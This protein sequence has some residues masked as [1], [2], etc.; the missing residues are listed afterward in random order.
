M[1]FL[2]IARERAAVYA[3]D[4]RVK[5]ILLSG[6]ASVGQTDAASDVDLLV[7]Y[8]G[9][10]G[11]QLLQA[12]KE[13][14]VASGG[15]FFWGTGE[16]FAV[17]HFQQ[18]SGIRVDV[19][20]AQVSQL[21]DR[22]AQLLEKHSL[23]L[24]LHLVATGILQAVPLYGA[25]VAE[26]WKRR[27]SAFPE[28]LATALVREHLRFS[29]RAVFMEMGADRGDLPFL[30]ELFLTTQKNLLGVMCGLN[31]MYHPGKVKRM[32]LPIEQMQIKPERFLERMLGLWRAPAHEAAREVCQLI[33]ETFDLVDQHMPSVPTA[34]KRQRFELPSRRRIPEGA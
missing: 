27:L 7:Y 3:A 1:E 32:W 30:A 29:P 15:G 25:E 17:Y 22:M 33:A 6:S 2:S 19:A 20:H 34:E 21:E 10:P 13:A 5:V 8:D 4:P 18:P 16:G 9:P 31:R 12:E 24:D 14:A 28:E 26:A 11:D 23:D